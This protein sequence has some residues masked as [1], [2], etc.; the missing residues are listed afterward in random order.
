MFNKLKD[1]H[2]NNFMEL[3][4]IYTE[5]RR[6]F[7]QTDAYTA[8]YYKDENLNILDMPT[9]YLLDNFREIDLL[10]KIFSDERII[11]NDVKNNNS[12]TTS[13]SI[14]IIDPDLFYTSLMAKKAITRINKI[15][16][17]R[18]LRTM[19]V[20]CIKVNDYERITK[21][22]NSDLINYNITDNTDIVKELSKKLSPYK[23][24]IDFF[25]K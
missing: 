14:I 10:F 7:H 3:H 22:M 11:T 16:I 5:K 1:I 25:I 4:N 24:P 13:N 15:Q 17:L 2:N 19:I 21:K 6:V 20:E 18:L 8:K 9:D 23:K 12:I